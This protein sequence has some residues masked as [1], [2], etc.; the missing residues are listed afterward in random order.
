MTVRNIKKNLAGAEDL[1]HGIGIESQS[2]GG[3]IY[4]MHKL[5]TYV[6]TYDIEE[7]KRSSLTFMRVY[8]TD[9]NYTD[10]RRNPTGTIGIPSDLGGVWEVIGDSL[11][12][13][14]L[15]AKQA[16][17]AGFN[18]VDGSFE[19]GAVTVNSN[20]VVWHW[21]T[22]KYYGGVIGTV[23]SGSTP[24]GSW[25]DKSTVTLKSLLSDIYGASIIK[26]STGHTVEDRFATDEANINSLLTVTS[27]QHQ[28]VGAS[29][30]K[31]LADGGYPVFACYG[32]STMWG[33]TV[34]NLGVKNSVNP[35]AMLANALNLLYGGTYTVNNRAISG[36][37]LYDMLRGTDGSGST[38][39][40]KI[41]TGG[42]D[43]GASVI[44]CNHGI[45]DSQL[46]KDI[47]QY[48]DD[49][50][51]FISLCRTNGK[52]PVLA[53]PN[54]NIDVPSSGII[55][56]VKAKRLQM[57]VKMMRTV[58][59]I[60]GVD[61]VDQYE[62]ISAT[63]KMIPM[64]TLIGD[65]AHP[66]TETYRQCGVNLAIPFI[67][68][69][70]IGKN[71][72]TASMDGATY[73]DNMTSSRQWQTY[74]R[75][76]ANLSANREASITGV[77][78]PVI[79]TE[80]R[81]VIS[82]IGLQ[83]TWAAN[84]S[85]SR[86]GITGTQVHYAQRQFGLTSLLDW[87][88]EMK[89]Y[90]SFYAGLNIVQLAFNLGTTGLGNGLTFGGVYLPPRYIACCNGANSV[91]EHNNRICTYDE[92]VTTPIYFDN[93]NGFELTDTG[94]N[95]V[96]K[97]VYASGVLTAALYVNGSASVTNTL[98][99]SGLASGFYP[100][101][102]YMTPTTVK[103]TFS[104]VATTFTITSPLPNLLVKTKMCSYTIAP[105]AGVVNGW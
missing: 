21:L 103:V 79:L 99:A 70:T 14:Q 95:T 63:S 9:I 28:L 80:P 69:H 92:V 17:E 22:G 85:V 86:N 6:P 64:S 84:C 77:N 62:F 45:N 72:D 105:G 41:S 65:G 71:F 42:I 67:C 48:R 13:R 51:T 97:I 32:D 43:A 44:I 26:T 100:V 31:Q 59:S 19:E 96:L 81:Q 25:I 8:W 57:Y 61:L 27:A 5:D 52:V 15:L 10:F 76:G 12:L 75:G 2:R 78:Y 83:W 39:A 11:K 88:S 33:A 37:T 60:F 93:A 104:N 20:D 18:L 47:N 102:V 54:P 73:Y 23:A 53:T 94:G 90:D 98:I 58:A 91:L 29:I 89:Y 16:A 30:A 56:E 3:A 4:E 55:S 74:G 34:G 38:F 101:S 82:L 50:I 87:D 24:T 49:L 36:T 46:N 35:P 7:M 66:S 1:L 68:A 40:S